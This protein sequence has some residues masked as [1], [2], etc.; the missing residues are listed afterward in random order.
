MQLGRNLRAV[1]RGSRQRRILAFTSVGAR[2]VRCG[3]PLLDV[4]EPRDLDQRI[5]SVAAHSAS[6]K[7]IVADPF[8]TIPKYKPRSACTYLSRFQRPSSK[9]RWTAREL[10]SASKP[11]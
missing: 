8:G 10:A 9:P 5:A 11:A 2:C 6:E 7:E 1:A 3:H 4:R